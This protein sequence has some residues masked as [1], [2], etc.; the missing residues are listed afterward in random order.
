[1]KF[2]FSFKKYFS[3]VRWP[4]GPQVTSYAGQAN[5]MSSHSL[6]RVGQ[7]DP[8]FVAKCRAN[9]CGQTNLHCHP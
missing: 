7:P 4:A 5:E 3:Y 1:M 6:R 9:L 8:H 2:Y